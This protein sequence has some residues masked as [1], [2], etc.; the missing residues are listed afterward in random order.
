MKIAAYK[1]PAGSTNTKS[2]SDVITRS[3]YR[4]S[5]D[6]W[7]NPR[8][9]SMETRRRIKSDHP[10]RRAPNISISTMHGRFS[11]KNYNMSHVP[12]FLAEKDRSTYTNRPQYCCIWQQS[13]RFQATPPNAL[14]WFRTRTTKRK[15]DSFTVQ[16]IKPRIQAIKLSRAIQQKRRNARLF[17]VQVATKRKISPETLS[18]NASSIDRPV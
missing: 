3:T 4:P 16:P 6:Q 2:Q 7:M 12:S 17:D 10:Q 11:E 9:F 1:Y 15:Q 8:S 18:S 13:F 5:T 14:V